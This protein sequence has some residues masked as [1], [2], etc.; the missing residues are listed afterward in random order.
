MLRN[1]ISLLLYAC[2]RYSMPCRVVLV[3]YVVIST[4][5]T[6]TVVLKESYFN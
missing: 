5:Y 1:K 4:L 3:Q 2:Y 6:S